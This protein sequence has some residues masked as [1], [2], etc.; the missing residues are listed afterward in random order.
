MIIDLD[1]TKKLSRKFIHWIDDAL[2]LKKVKMQIT[3]PRIFLWHF[4]LYL[5]KA[6]RIF[7][8]VRIPLF[9]KLFK[10]I[11]WSLPLRVRRFRPCNLQGFLNCMLL[12]VTHSRTETTPISECLTEKYNSCMYLKPNK[13]NFCVPWNQKMVG[14]KK[15]QELY[16]VHIMRKRLREFKTHK[17]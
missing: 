9:Y 16:L 10:F 4:C 12:P 2:F 1:V 5:G 8:I 11:R 17:T 3:I 7:I 14:I 15:R 13:F 6:I